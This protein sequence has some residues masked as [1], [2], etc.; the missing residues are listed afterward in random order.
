MVN[1]KHFVLIYLVIIATFLAGCSSTNEMELEKSNLRRQIAFQQHLQNLNSQN[2]QLKKSLTESSTLNRENGELL[3]NSLLKENPPKLDQTLKEYKQVSQKTQM[4][5]DSI[6]RSIEDDTEKNAALLKMLEEFSPQNYEQQTSLDQMETALESGKKQE[7]GRDNVHIGISPQQ[8]SGS[9]N[10]TSKDE[11]KDINY[12]YS[13]TMSGA[14]FTYVGENNAAFGLKYMTLSG[15]LEPE[16]DQLDHDYYKVEGYM[17]FISVGYRIPAF[18]TFNVIP[19][20]VYGVGE[21]LY[22]L[23]KSGSCSKDDYLK[24]N[25]TAVGME[26]PFYHQLSVAFSWGFKLTGY[27]ITSD[28]ADDYKN[29]SK[30]RTFDL[31]TEAT[32]AGIGLMAGLAW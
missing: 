12:N 2:E 23:C 4:T 28:S 5:L 1:T 20:L 14:Y 29:D 27:R 26:I 3:N 15:K 18:K 16:E 6:K 13:G 17:G 11:N 32:Y 19:E 30:T 9:A 21:N 22:L 10:I 24:S 8:M 25:I 31:K 7:R